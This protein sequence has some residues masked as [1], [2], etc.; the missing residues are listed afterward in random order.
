M[1]LLAT[2]LALSAP[3]LLHSFKQRKLE[4]EATQ[5]LAVTE[6][7]RN[8]AISKGVPM[9]VWIDAESGSFGVQASDGYEGDEKR[10]KYYSLDPEIH[11]DP[12]EAAPD[13]EGH[14][15]LA[16]FDPEG[17]LS[18]ESATFIHL[19]NRA[20]DGIS[21]QQTEDGWG[22]EIVKEEK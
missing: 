2:L 21:L 11:F 17:T 8:E 10:E 3:T 14:M 20:P 1:A 16:T 13:Q 9:N 5:L 6:Y 7:A 18:L 15:I 12:L 4:Q 19:V 22:Y